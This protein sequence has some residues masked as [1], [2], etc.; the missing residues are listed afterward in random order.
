MILNVQYLIPE[1][2]ILDEYYRWVFVIMTHLYYIL[3]NL[4]IQNINFLT[5][6]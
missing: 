3:K 6:D 4:L 1:K 2:K 5:I